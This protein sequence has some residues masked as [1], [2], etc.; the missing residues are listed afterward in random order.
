MNFIKALIRDY[1]VNKGLI[2]FDT[3]TLSN[4]IVLEHFVVRGERN[5]KRTIRVEIKK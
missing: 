1:K 4:G 2:P 5:N 3:V